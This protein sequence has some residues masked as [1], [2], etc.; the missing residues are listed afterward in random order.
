MVVPLLGTPEHKLKP[1]LR[2]LYFEAYT[3]AALDVQRRASPGRGED[4]PS[5]RLPALE[6]VSWLKA[7]KA[8]LHGLV[9]EEEL[10]DITSKS[11]NNIEVER[12]GRKQDP[13]TQHPY[14]RA[15]TAS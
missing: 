14:F 3:P 7:I 8:H 2:R 5:K 6:R 11:E 1:Q 10:E 9:I 15:R 13:Y 12:L 4:K